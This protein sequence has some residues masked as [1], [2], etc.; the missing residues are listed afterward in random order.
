MKYNWTLNNIGLQR[1]KRIFITGANSG[2][3]FHASVELARRGATVVM[4]CR[5]LQRGEEAVDKLR[6]TVPGADVELTQLD[7]A[8][9]SSV[10]RAAEIELEK[11]LPLHVLINNAGVMAPPERLETAD[12][13]ELQFGTNVLGHF[14]LTQKLMPQLEKADAARVVNVASIA[15][16][17]GQVQFDDLQSKVKYDPMRSYAQSKLANLLFTFELQ[18]RLADS[19]V[20]SLACHPGVA[21]TNLFLT[22]DY[23]FLERL[24]RTI[25]SY[26]IGLFLNS[27]I[28][29]AFPT[30]YAATAEL[31]E[32][33]GYYGPQGFK[34]MRGGD[35]GEAQV[36]P[37][38]RSLEDAQRLWEVCE[39]LTGVKFL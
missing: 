20:I 31:A 12:G 9:L 21:S 16:K 18:R 4:A 27:E 6:Q 34:E 25:A 11:R 15:H 3:G 14:L 19:S 1:G 33:G 32:G 29:G 13:F 35:V 7:L 10:R 22:G 38:A 2:I 30:L 37:Q 28:Q 36:R 8:S 23:G 39:E 5:S 24:I 17:R 26:A